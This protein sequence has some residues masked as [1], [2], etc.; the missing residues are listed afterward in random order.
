MVCS[1]NGEGFD[2]DSCFN[3]SRVQNDIP[4]LL[5]HRHCINYNLKRAGDYYKRSRVAHTEIE[6]AYLPAMDFA[7]LEVEKQKYLDSLFSKY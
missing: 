3:M 2:T 7:A 6:K 5:E 4:L 1:D